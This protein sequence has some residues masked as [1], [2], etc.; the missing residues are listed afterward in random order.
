[1]GKKKTDFIIAII[2]SEITALYFIIL[3]SGIRNIWLLFVVFPLLGVLGIWLARLIGRKLPF[4]Y[5]LAK[6]LITGTAAA[7]IDLAILNLLIFI[8][9][10]AAG[11]GFSFFKA[12]SFL[13]AFSAKY[14]GDKFWAFESK[15]IKGL[16]REFIKFGAA[17]FIGLL[18]NVV[19]ASVIVAIG[20]Q[21]G[22]SLK[23]WA[24]VAGITAALA[25]VLW[26]FPAYKYW[27]FK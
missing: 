16:G 4:V 6:F 22:F 15:R 26:N 3:F 7:L 9:G 21:F 18:I 8:S 23:V 2:I 20:P 27:V 11:P 25:T 5:Q 10:I 24:N 19:V 13:I 1:M 14:L 17:T 12:V